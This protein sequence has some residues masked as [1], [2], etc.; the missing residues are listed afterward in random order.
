MQPGIQTEKRK[1]RV[2]PYEKKRS[3]SAGQTELTIQRRWCGSFMRPRPHLCLK[4]QSVCSF[5]FSGEG[6]QFSSLPKKIDSFV[7]WRW[8]CFYLNLSD[9]H[10]MTLTFNPGYTWGDV[11]CSKDRNTSYCNREGGREGEEIGNEAWGKKWVKERWLKEREGGEKSRQQRPW[12]YFGPEKCGSCKGCV[13]MKGL[14]CLL[15][16]NN[17]EQS[18]VQISLPLVLC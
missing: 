13:F 5:C 1:S 16:Y 11:V 18:P 9:P 7:E 15:K 3:G 10:K 17:R 14:L 12:E 6:C 4:E 2:K 8:F